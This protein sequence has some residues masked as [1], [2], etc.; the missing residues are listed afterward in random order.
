MP[1]CRSTSGADPLSISISWQVGGYVGSPERASSAQSAAWAMASW[2]APPLFILKTP[3]RRSTN[4]FRSDQVTGRGSRTRRLRFPC[5]ERRKGEVVRPA[6]P[7]RADPRPC[8]SHTRRTQ[9]IRHGVFVG[10]ASSDT[11]LVR[12]LRRCHHPACLSFA[13]NLT[14][15]CSVVVTKGGENTSI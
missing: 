2:W 9:A 11:L 15:N 4:E 12:L 13:G 14:R 7:T 10:Q 1:P 8:L 5:S 6:G 3:S